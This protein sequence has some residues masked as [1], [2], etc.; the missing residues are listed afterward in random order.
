MAVVISSIMPSAKYSCSG[1][2]DMFWN[3]STAR[4]GQSG[5]DIHSIAVDV[6]VLPDDDVAQIDA[7]TE[8]DPLRLGRRRIALG[9]PTLHGNRASDSLY[10]AREFDQDAV[11]GG[12]DNATFVVGNLWI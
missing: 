1:S 12:F 4:D 2:P 10:D 5:G 3:G 9:H 8:H 7:D 6:V 11:A